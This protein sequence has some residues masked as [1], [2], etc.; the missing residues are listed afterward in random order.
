MNRRTLAGWLYAAMALA[1]ALAAGI[2]AGS[3]GAAAYGAEVQTGS[4]DEASPETVRVQRSAGGY[5]RDRDP[6]TLR[7]VLTF[8]ETLTRRRQSAVQSK[9][10]AESTVQQSTTFSVQYGDHWV[11]DAG[12]ELFF[13]AD[14]DGFYHYLRV[15][16]DVDSYFDRAYV[17]A[18]LYTSP[19]GQ[20]WD[21]YYETDDFLVTGAV[22]D[23]AYEVESELV[24]NYPPGS[25][26]VLLEIYDADS[27]VLVDEF[28]PEESS[29][30]S[31]LPLEDTRFDGLPPPPVVVSS[32]HGGGGSMAWITWL[33]LA[34]AGSLRLLRRAKKSPT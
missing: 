7:D 10:S 5:A 29:A 11:Y 18:R 27:G 31:L 20:T 4:G 14:G 15:H 19:D 24:A 21:L 22:A 17:F 30:F 28:G 16:F 2:D 33:M 32:G 12:T 13:D 25:Y 6:D 3:G 1:V 23:D 9:A 26:D 8:E 34:A